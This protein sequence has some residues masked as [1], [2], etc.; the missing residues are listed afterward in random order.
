MVEILAGLADH[1]QPEQHQSLILNPIM[2]GNTKTPHDSTAEDAG[3]KV[4]WRLAKKTNQMALALKLMEDLAD[5]GIGTNEVESQEWRRRQARQ[6]KMGIKNVTPEKGR[7]KKISLVKEDRI[8][9]KKQMVMRASQARE[10][11][12][13]AKKLFQKHLAKLPFSDKNVKNT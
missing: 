9:V 7:I 10:D 1:L 13:E 4:L 5:Q 11:W 3:L 8:N 2:D 12:K 6:A